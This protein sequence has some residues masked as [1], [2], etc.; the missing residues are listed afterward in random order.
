[1]DLG[2]RVCRI[3]EE[4][5]D[6]NDFPLNGDRRGG[7]RWQCKNCM[8]NRNKQWRSSNKSRVSEYNKKRKKKISQ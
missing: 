7:R 1:M 2:I 4:E 8:R 3:C 6:L 5:K